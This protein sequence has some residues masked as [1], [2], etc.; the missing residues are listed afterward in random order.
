M[1]ELELSET[2]L[3]IQT[4]F[5]RRFEELIFYIRTRHRGLQMLT[6]MYANALTSKENKATAK[7]G[8]HNLGAFESYLR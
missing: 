5:L 7:E 3:K 6:T 4:A 2:A 8:N 1:N